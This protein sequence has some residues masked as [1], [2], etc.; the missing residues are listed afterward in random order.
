M[1]MNMTVAGA[2]IVFALVTAAFIS[3]SIASRK[4]QHIE[5]KG[6][7]FAVLELFTSEGCSSCPPAE[8]LLA[9]IQA[10]AAGKPIYVLA[11][12]VDYW[13]RNGWKDPYSDAA[14]SK[15]QVDYSRQF[16]G[17]VYTP[18]LIINGQ[19]ECIGSD[20]GA[21]RNA[22]SAALRTSAANTLQLSGEI[23][24]GGADLEYALDNDPSNCYLLVAV[25]Q[26]S[27]TTNVKGGENEGRILPHVQLVR[28]LET[29]N[30]KGH[31]T[32]HIHVKLPAG[33]NTREWEITGLVQQNS[34]GAVTAAAHATLQ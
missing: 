15:R 18:Q 3:S 11:Y 29:M 2:L 14:F 25:V 22:L 7:S 23:K 24:P 26:R 32:G 1:K 30:L 20:A 28:G 17:Q 19:S 34:N 13:D 10:Q 21:V 6:N 27:A 31:K 33:F 16:A 8:E 5:P 9:G 12:H 4:L